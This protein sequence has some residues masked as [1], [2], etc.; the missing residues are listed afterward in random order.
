MIDL[1]TA[2]DFDRLLATTPDP[3]VSIYLPTHR[4]GMETQQDRVR[5]KNLVDRATST[6]VD[7]YMRPPQARAMLEPAD[8]LLADSTF[9]SHQGDGLAVFAA[10]GWFDWFRLPVRVPDV[11]RVSSRFHVAPLA[12]VVGANAEFHILAL[13]QNA[14]RLLHGTRF[15]VSEVELRDVPTSVAEALWFEDRERQLQFHQTGRSGRT[16]FAAVFHGQGLGADT[17]DEEIE[18]FFRAVDAGIRGLVDHRVPVVLAGVAYLFPIYRRASQLQNIAEGGVEGNPEHLSPAELHR[19]ALPVVEP[20][21]DSDRVAAV[22][23]FAAGNEPVA[24]TIEEVT[25]AAHQGRIATVFLDTT[26]TIWGRVRPDGLGVDIVDTDDEGAVDLGNEIAAHT[27]RNRGTVFL[28][29][30]VPGGGDV[31]AILRF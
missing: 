19:R 24:S 2:E 14:V 21:F 20:L 5:L 13:S 9:W 23:R 12:P 18:R 7:R 1:L 17:A 11:V 4:A 31:A 16:G 10:N 30:E 22:Q 26:R 3:A 27:W 15:G 28:V 6:L 8:E 25:V 29:D